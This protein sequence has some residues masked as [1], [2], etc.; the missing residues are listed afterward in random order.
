M[1]LTR[2][3]IFEMLVYQKRFAAVGLVVTASFA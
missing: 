2:L 1:D 3:V